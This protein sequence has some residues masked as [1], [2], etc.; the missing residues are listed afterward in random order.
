V[1]EGRGLDSTQARHPTRLLEVAKL[2]LIPS[3]CLGASV[4]PVVAGTPGNAAPGTTVGFR[5]AGI[6]RAVAT[7]AGSSVS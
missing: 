6:V 4:P 1:G 3:S 5:S 7:E 2:F